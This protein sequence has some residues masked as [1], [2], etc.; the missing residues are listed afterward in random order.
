MRQEVEILN[1]LG[2][3]ARPSGQLAQLAGMFASEV[4]LE[5]GERRINAKSIMGIMMLAAGQGRRL[6]LETS[7]R[8]EE[9]AMKAIVELIENRFGEE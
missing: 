7:G 5:R 9:A 2:L 6:I 4:W 1:K 8:D 3:H